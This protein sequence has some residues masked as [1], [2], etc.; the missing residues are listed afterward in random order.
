MIF[1]AANGGL[2]GWVNPGDVVPE[3]EKVMSNLSTLKIPLQR[4]MVAYLAG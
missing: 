4:L 3:F 2:L 1:S